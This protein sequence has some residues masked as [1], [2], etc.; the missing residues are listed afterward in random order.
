MAGIVSSGADLRLNAEVVRVENV[1]SLESRSQKQ[2]VRVTTG[3]GHMEAFDLAVLTAPLGW[4]K[5]NRRVFS[6]EL[7]PRLSQAIGAIGCGNLEKIFIRFPKAFWDDVGREAGQGTFPIES[8]FLKPKYAPETN[9]RQW[10][11][12]IISFSGLPEPHAQPVIMFFTYGEWGCRIS[13]LITGKYQESS[14][15]Y[16][17]LDSHLRSYY[18]RLP[19]FNMESPDCKP[20]RF[21]A[22][23]WANDEFAGFGSFTNFPVRQEDGAKDLRVLQEGLGIERGV[24]FAG[25]HVAPTK[26]SGTVMGAY[27]SGEYVAKAII[28][29]FQVDKTLG[30]S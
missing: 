19:N 17:I 4:L 3:N 29:S 10:R 18:F 28:D 5:R 25:E 23:D 26:G 14:G 8:L 15:F 16:D 22:T 30:K 20:T 13:R 1:E 7:P 6:P 24:W 21:L 11:Q 27:Q 12:E 2:R 9:P